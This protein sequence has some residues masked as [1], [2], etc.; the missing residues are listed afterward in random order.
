MT[1]TNQTVQHQKE[2]A[3]IKTVLPAVFGAVSILAVLQASD[4]HA[5]GPVLKIATEGAF[6][7]FN[8]T[9]PSGKLEGFDVD[10]TNAACAKAGLTCEWVRQDWD[11]LIPGLLAGKFDAISA[12]VS[13]TDE[14][15]K[16]VA[17]TNKLYQTA[18]RFVAKK[19]ALPNSEPGTLKGKSVGAQR[20]TIASTYLQNADLGVDIKLY[21]TQDAMRLDLEAGRIDVLLADEVATTRGFLNKP[22]GQEFATFGTP[23]K[24][25]D[26]I[27]I[28]LRKDEPNAVE[29]LNEGIAAIHQDG[30]F[31]KLS[32]Q[33]FSGFDLH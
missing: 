12:S 31:Q 10:V 11:G 21:D 7:P 32:A 27:G 28:A 30:T 6:E 5:Q 1:R 4:A 22:E 14:R 26:G 3:M 8:Y 15:K 24:V 16:R 33:Y 9:A 20:A 18:L 2:T 23:I 17:F 13:I 19:G 25:G 29:K